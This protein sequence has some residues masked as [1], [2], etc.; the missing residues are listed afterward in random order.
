MQNKR[1]QK[2]LCKKVEVRHTK[3]DGKGSGLFALGDI[4]KDDYANEYLGEI[5]YK[6][7]ENNYV[8]KI[9]GINL[10]IN[11]DKNSGPAQYI[12]CLCNP[13]CD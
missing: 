1:V 12:N 9:N 2:C 8:M 11:G 7:W 6:R 4:E 5:E 3:Q 10:W 13:N